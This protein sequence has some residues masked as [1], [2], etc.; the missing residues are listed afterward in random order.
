MNECRKMVNSH[1][2]LKLFHLEAASISTLCFKIYKTSV[3]LF[4]YTH[5]FITD[6]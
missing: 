4:A 6:Q 2:L 5:L 3:V 1:M